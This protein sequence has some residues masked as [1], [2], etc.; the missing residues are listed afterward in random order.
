[1]NI[2]WI[3]PPK[4]AVGGMAGSVRVYATGHFRVQLLCNLDPGDLCPISL[5]ILNTSHGFIGEDDWIL[6]VPGEVDVEIVFETPPGAMQGQRCRFTPCVA[7]GGALFELARLAEED[8]PSD[9]LD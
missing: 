8:P 4:S 7:Q 2:G 3:K 9:R 1:M 5:R 6:G